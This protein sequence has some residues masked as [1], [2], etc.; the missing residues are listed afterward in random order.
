MLR[1]AVVVGKGGDGHRRAQHQVDLLEQR[2]ELLLAGAR[3]VNRIPVAVA[4]HH[5]AHQFGTRAAIVG[6]DRRVHR[7]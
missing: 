5:A 6:R 3:V 7:K 4:Q 2:A 1:L